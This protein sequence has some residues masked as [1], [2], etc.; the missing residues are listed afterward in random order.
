MTAQNLSLAALTAEVAMLRE[1]AARGAPARKRAGRGQPTPTGPGRTPSGTR[2]A[3]RRP[4]GKSASLPSTSS[5]RPESPGAALR[6]VAELAAGVLE[7]RDTDTVPGDWSDLSTDNRWA[8]GGEMNCGP[9]K[10]GN[11]VCGT[12]KE[13]AERADAAGHAPHAGHGA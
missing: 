2:L 7:L 8:P 6:A 3:M 13:N 11:L 4:C 12:P 5:T 10:P 9:G 1:H